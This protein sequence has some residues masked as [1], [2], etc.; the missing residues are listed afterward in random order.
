MIAP[1]IALHAPSHA[2]AALRL[3]TRQAAPGRAFLAA[4]EIA[5]DPG[6]HVY[7]KNPGD[8][9]VPTKIAW[10]VPRGWRVEPLEFPKPHRFTPGGVTAYGYEG[11]TLFLARVTPGATAGTVAADV[12]WLVCHEACIAGAATVSARI[13]VGKRNLPTPDAARLRVARNALPL[14]APGWRFAAVRSGDKLRLVA[15]PPKGA[16]PAK[17]QFFPL[18]GGQIDQAKAAL[19]TFQGGRYVFNMDPS[20]FPEAQARLRGL[21]DLGP[22]ARPVLLDPVL[23][24]P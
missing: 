14:A 2:R 11:K 21:L 4:V 20:P 7:W 19:A 1:L 23:K 18:D 16:R 13:T 3:E 9:G 8:S 22:G 24:A 17:A 15:T 5:T 6:W 12:R 10:R